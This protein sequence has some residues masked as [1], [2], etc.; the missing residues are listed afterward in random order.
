MRILRSD[1]EKHR[2]QWAETAQ[3]NNWYAQ[4]FFIQVWVNQHGIITDSLS[5]IGM[6]QDFIIDTDTDEELDPLTYDII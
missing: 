3:K 6:K 5:H 4:P 1:I 2:K